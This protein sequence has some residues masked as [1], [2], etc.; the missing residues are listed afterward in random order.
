MSRKCK[1]DQEWEKALKLID[2][3]DAVIARQVIENYQQTGVVL[4]GLPP[5]I[6]MILLLVKPLIDRRRRA[7][8]AARRRR[9][10][11]PVTVSASEVAETVASLS[12]EWPERISS[13]V[14]PVF[15]GTQGRRMGSR[16]RW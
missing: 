11:R 8:E 12:R 1:F 15:A 6:E 13:V 5:Q 10:K 9:L 4:S 2:E 7:T 16:L 14:D 3:E